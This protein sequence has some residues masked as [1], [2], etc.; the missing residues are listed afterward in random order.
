MLYRPASLFPAILLA[1]AI[2]LAGLHTSPSQPRYT[3]LHCRKI[4][5]IVPPLLQFPRVASCCTTARSNSA[6]G[7]GQR[8]APV[9][10][11]RNISPKL[12]PAFRLV[13]EFL[14]P[15]LPLRI[16]NRDRENR[17]LVFSVNWRSPLVAFTTICDS[18]NPTLAASK[19]TSARDFEVIESSLPW[20]VLEIPEPGIIR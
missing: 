16:C 18:G 17:R 1:R 5:S 9:P 12:C 6:Y 2:M 7:V 15:P 8:I 10:P 3:S 20:P 4:A 14:P 11:M 13:T 19:N